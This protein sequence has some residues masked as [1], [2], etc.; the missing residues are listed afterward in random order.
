MMFPVTEQLLKT[1]RHTTFDL[2]YG[3]E[4]APLIVFVHGW[5]E[6]SRHVR[7]GGFQ[8]GE[9][10]VLPDIPSAVTNVMTIMVAECIAAKLT[11]EHPAL[12]LSRAGED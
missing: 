3:A 10:D 11:H 5:P 2:A 9:A 1:E 6:L 12:E 7:D 8:S 4:P